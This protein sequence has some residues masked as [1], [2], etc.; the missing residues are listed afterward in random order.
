[1]THLN[2]L[3]ALLKKKPKTWLTFFGLLMPA[4]GFGQDVSASSATSDSPELLLYTAMA[5]VVIVA[6]LVLIVALYTLTIIKVIIRK[7]KV[8]ELAEQGVA[9][10]EGPG[11]WA[12]F[13]QKMTDAVPLEKE[14][15]V[16]LDHNYDGIRELDNHLPPWWKYMFYLSIVFAVVY[17]L[18]YHVF[19]TLPLQEEEYQ[20]EL[21]VASEE[22]E[23]RKLLAVNELDE[24]SVEVT[25][26][27]SELANGKDIFEKSC[28]V[29]HAA[30]GGGGVGPNLTDVYWL[31]GGSINDV[32]KTIKYGVP[33]K[34]MIAWQATLKPTDIRD[35]ASYI[36][37][38]QGTTPASPKEPQGDPY[39]PGAAGQ[40]SG[41]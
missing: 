36:L 26:V 17:L 27:E 29:C 18:A 20:N 14:D 38:M 32:F 13:N 15:A 30:D 1:M 16:L 28:A 2:R 5:L 41:N 9:Y 24:N 40:E 35:V 34:G 19:D 37:T 10:E 11:F 4:V 25:T 33:Q 6:V 12:R 31:H 7:E 23:A 21:A 39:E 8:S 3:L 22:A